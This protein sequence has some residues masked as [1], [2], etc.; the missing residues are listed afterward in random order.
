VHK[1]TNATLKKR[2]KGNKKGNQVMLAIDHQSRSDTDNNDIDNYS[3]S[4]LW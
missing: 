1:A 3:N 2:D 4:G